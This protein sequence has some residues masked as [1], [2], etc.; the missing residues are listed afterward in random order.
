MTDTRFAFQRECA[1]DA[2]TNRSGLILNVGCNEDPAALKALDEERVVNCDLYGHDH[3]LKRPNAADML[4]DAATEEWPF[5]NDEGALVVLGDILEHMSEK[6]IEAT[7]R[8]ARRVAPSVCITVPEDYRPEVNAEEAGKHPR[9][10]VHCTTVTYDMLDRLL[11]RT[12]WGSAQW[13]RVVY[14]DG[15]SWGQRTM[16]WFVLAERR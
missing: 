7:L 6:D 14:D 12:G 10:I 9:G 3:F 8:E 11:A 4:F 2:L 15:S 5:E 13:R 16:G 1:Q